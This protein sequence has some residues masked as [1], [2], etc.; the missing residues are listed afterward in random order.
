MEP[1][2]QP[3]TGPHRAAPPPAAPIRIGLALGGG[4]VRGAAHIGVLDV[5]HRAGIVPA[6]VTGSSAG[7]L[8]G[9]LYAAGMST[10][11]ITALAAS[12][13]WKKLVRPAMSRRALFDTARLA[14][15]LDD[16]LDARRFD[17]LNLAFAAIACDL[18]TGRRVVLRDGPVSTAV[19][20]SSAIP[21]VFPPVDRDGMVLVDGGLADMVPAGLARELGAD[22]VVAVDVSGPLPRRRPRTLLQILVAT[23]TLQPGGID[24]LERDADLVL[25]PEVDAYAFWELS[26]IA[27]FIQAGREAAERALPLVRALVTV[28]EA[29]REFQLTAGPAAIGPVR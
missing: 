21:G 1:T 4:A 23:G 25:S 15:F 18:T 24:R 10:T 3:D 28:A 13:H 16:A 17:A 2:S 5:F 19:L 29:R 7:A 6:V 9:A 12:L 26:R 22:I 14:R 20:A 11:D 8:V 27:E